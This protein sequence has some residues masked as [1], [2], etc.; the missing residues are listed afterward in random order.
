MGSKL[1]KI[2]TPSGGLKPCSFMLSK[3]SHSYG[4]YFL[5]YALV[6]AEFHLLQPQW[7]PGVYC[8]PA[9]S[10]PLTW[11]GVLFIRQGPYQGGVFRYRREDFLFLD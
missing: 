8:L 7:L 1:A 5:E 3:G 4:S 2:C 11:W 10:S 9:H 6:A